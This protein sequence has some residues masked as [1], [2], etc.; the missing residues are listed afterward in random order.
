MVVND[1]GWDTNKI[2][3]FYLPNRPRS[4]DVIQGMTTAISTESIST[5]QKSQLS[6]L[7]KDHGGKQPQPLSKKSSLHPP[8]PKAK[9]KPQ[10]EKRI[11]SRFFGLGKRRSNSA[12]S[13]ASRK[14]SKGSLEGLEI[15]ETE[16]DRAIVPPP[17]SYSDPRGP[18][19]DGARSKSPHHPKPRHPR[20]LQQQQPEPHK[21]P[22]R[23]QGGP[24]G[25]QV[26]FQ[27]QP[28]G[29]KTESKDFSISV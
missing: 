7:S 11:A 3:S 23:F 27:G 26:T 2:L 5:S 1:G 20:V 6:A 8:G 21:R 15:S 28:N 25:P 24:Q 4:G 12:G 9:E 18:R 29:A 17:R 16:C 19:H 13:M 22:P 10:G 14:S